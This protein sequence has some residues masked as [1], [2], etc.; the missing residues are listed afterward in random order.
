MKAYLIISSIGDKVVFEV[1]TLS[2]RYPDD[3]YTVITKDYEKHIQDAENYLKAKG[4]E[5]VD[6]PLEDDGEEEEIVKED[7]MKED[8]KVSVTKEKDDKGRFTYTVYLPN[9]ESFI[10]ITN[11]KKNKDTAQVYYNDEQ[12]YWIGLEKK[13]GSTNPYQKKFNIYQVDIKEV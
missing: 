11:S 7:T 2:G 5:I 6:M 10:Y 12:G 9:G 1:E 4:Y 13:A 3:Q 8:K